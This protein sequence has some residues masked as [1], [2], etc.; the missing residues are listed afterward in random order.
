M[1]IRTTAH[2]IH[3]MQRWHQC[4]PRQ[5][6]INLRVSWDTFQF[7]RKSEEHVPSRGNLA[8]NS[9][10]GAKD[11]FPTRACLT[12]GKFS[13]T[14]KDIVEPGRK[15]LSRPLN[16]QSGDLDPC[17][18]AEWT[19]LARIANVAQWYCIDSRLFLIRLV[20]SDLSH[21]SGS[22]ILS[23]P[24]QGLSFYVTCT[25]T[26][27]TYS[28]LRAR[29][30]GAELWTLSCMYKLGSIDLLVH[31][32]WSQVVVRNSN[33]DEIDISSFTSCKGSF[34]NLQPRLWLRV[35]AFKS[36]NFTVLFQ[37]KRIGYSQFNTRQP[38]FRQ[39]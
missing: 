10:L 23:W 30:W 5:Q 12:Q 26:S 17:R 28:L 29:G 35:R 7:T 1:Y 15:S 18:D 36:T 2:A 32:F 20:L 19:D 24:L 38:A 39:K 22:P 3:R 4:Y 31:E 11:L 8:V 34:R 27:S 25:S 16:A 14:N 9:G 37:L 21:R 13:K 6:P 33:F